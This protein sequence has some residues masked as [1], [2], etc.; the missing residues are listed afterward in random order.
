MLMDGIGV[1]V[2]TKL[3]KATTGGIRFFII[4]AL[5][6]VVVDCGG[7]CGALDGLVPLVVWRFGSVICRQCRKSCG[8][9][10]GDVIW[11]GVRVWGG[12]RVA[13]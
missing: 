7:R 3:G 9:I 13:G 5:I 1:E 6:V 12:A 2:S 11:I 8:D 10:M 4:F